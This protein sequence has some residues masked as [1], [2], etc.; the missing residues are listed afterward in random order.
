MHAMHAGVAVNDCDAA[1]GMGLACFVMLVLYFFV[2]A[3][4][5]APLH[6]LAS[7]LAPF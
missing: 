1:I 3:G 7:Q 2:A 5:S 4:S 6:Q